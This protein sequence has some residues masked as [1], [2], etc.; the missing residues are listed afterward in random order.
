[1]HRLSNAVAG[2][3]ERDEGL[4]GCVLGTR[5]RSMTGKSAWVVGGQTE[6]NRGQASVKSN[7]MTTLKRAYHS[8]LDFP[9]GAVH[10]PQSPAWHNLSHRWKPHPTSLL[11]VVSIIYLGR[12][13]SGNI[14]YF[15]QTVPH[16]TFSLSN[17]HFTFGIVCFPHAQ[18]L[19]VK[20]GHGGQ[21][22][23]SG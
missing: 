6:R 13:A 22:V 15:P 2:A 9:H 14:T 12:I 4:T 20:N 5:G 16:P 8:F 21:A 1:M 23:L 18:S 10:A 17:E 11:N 7:T 3:G 19:F